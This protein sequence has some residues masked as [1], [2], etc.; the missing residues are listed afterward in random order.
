MTGQQHRPGHAFAELLD[1]G[2]LELDLGTVKR[3]A[4]DTRI[5]LRGYRS[6]LAAARQNR[7]GSSHTG[8]DCRA[9]KF[10]SIHGLSPFYLVL[11]IGR[12]DTEISTRSLF[13]CSCGL[14][15]AVEAKQIAWVELALDLTQ[16][17]IRRAVVADSLGA[18]EIDVV[19]VAAHKRLELVIPLAR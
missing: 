14:Y 5:G 1:G 17:F 3:N 18:I 2:F 12:S 19:V 9:A 4:T 10:T 8:S 13:S 11:V 16:S 15:V 6:L 7:N